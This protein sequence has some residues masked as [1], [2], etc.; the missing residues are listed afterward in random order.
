MPKYLI[1]FGLSIVILGS[2]AYS[3]LYSHQQDQQKQQQPEQQQAPQP[4]PEQQQPEPQP[5]QQQEQEQAPQQGSSS[6]RWSAG[7]GCSRKNP[8]AES[9][10]ELNGIEPNT[11]GCPCQKKCVNGYTQE[12]LRREK[13]VYICENACHKDRCFCPDP[14]KT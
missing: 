6:H 10:T 8:N 3:S 13:G 4:Q 2:G 12:D 14:C 1:V 9:G 7:S 5:E 11:V